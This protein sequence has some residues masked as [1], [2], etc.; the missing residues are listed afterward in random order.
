L[1]AMHSSSVGAAQEIY[2]VAGARGRRLGAPLHTLFP[3]SAVVDIDSFAGF[4]ELMVR[5]LAGRVRRLV[6]TDTR[7]PERAGI[8]AE[9]C[10]A[11]EVEY[12]G[13]SGSSGLSLGPIPEP[14]VRENYRQFE[15]QW[16]A[17]G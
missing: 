2:V 1:G 12:V 14:L 5:I 6:L 15:A 11:C 8:L 13:P 9:V 16:R 7:Y 17:A 3:D 10:G 4:F